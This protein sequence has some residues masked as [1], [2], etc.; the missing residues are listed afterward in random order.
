M[1]EF[2]LLSAHTPYIITLLAYLLSMGYYA[3]YKP[4][5]SVSEEQ[6]DA[7][8]IIFTTKADIADTLSSS[9]SYIFKA[10]VIQKKEHFTLSQHY[11]SATCYFYFYDYSEQ[12]T[13]SLISF[14]QYSRP[15]TGC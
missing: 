12:C 8:H 7:K 10:D 4:N 9:K 5:S 11:L 2:G 14:K 13:S 6:T 3:A 15:P 1:F